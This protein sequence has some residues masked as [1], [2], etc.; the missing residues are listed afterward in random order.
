MKIYVTGGRADQ[1]KIMRA[2]EMLKGLYKG[3]IEVRK[4]NY[5]TLKTCKEFAQT[6]F[7]NLD[8]ADEVT[9]ITDHMEE[10]AHEVVYAERQGKKVYYF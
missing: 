9:V 5:D 1:N 10:V 2:T 3:S 8:W 7:D 6:S 4:I